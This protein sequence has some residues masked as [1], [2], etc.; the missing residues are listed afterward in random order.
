MELLNCIP[1]NTAPEVHFEG[2]HFVVRRAV[3]G[4]DQ[5]WEYCRGTLLVLG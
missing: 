1:R 4:S 5:M 2:D 3:E